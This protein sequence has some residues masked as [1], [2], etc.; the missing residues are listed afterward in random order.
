[1]RFVWGGACSV[2]RTPLDL[3]NLFRQATSTVDC[4]NTLCTAT[5]NQQ[6]GC[7][8]VTLVMVVGQQ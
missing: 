7:D 4:Y 1:M 5:L 6:L 2:R 3:V 8:T